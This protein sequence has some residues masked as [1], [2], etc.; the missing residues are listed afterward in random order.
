MLTIMQGPAKERDL[1][2]IQEVFPFFCRHYSGIR[3]RVHRTGGG[4]PRTWFHVDVPPLHPKHVRPKR[5]H[6]DQETGSGAPPD[7]RRADYIVLR[8]LVAPPAHPQAKPHQR[9]IR[10]RR[11]VDVLLARGAGGADAS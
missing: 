3:N 4:G 10:R 7:D 5:E 8:L 6:P 2:D 9:P 11:R 1:G